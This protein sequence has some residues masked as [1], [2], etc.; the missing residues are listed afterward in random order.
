MSEGGLKGERRKKKGERD[1]AATASQR[2]GH[3]RLMIYSLYGM[4]DW[5]IHII[6]II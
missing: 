2:T 5:D 1:G 3:E 6:Y 4:R